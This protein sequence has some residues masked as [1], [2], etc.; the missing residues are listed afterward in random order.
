[1]PSEARP[2]ALLVGQSLE[3]WRDPLRAAVTA[4]DLDTVAAV[5]RR[6]LELG[7]HALDVNLG[8]SGDPAV[9]RAAL[10]AIRQAG[11]DV[12]LFLDT[13]DAR[14][15]TG[16]LGVV[17]GPVVTNAVPATD[18]DAPALLEAAAR[19]GAGVVLTPR[20][21][22]RADPAP[23][24]VLVR[25]LEDG[26]E[27]ARA[28]GVDGPLYLDCL[29]FPPAHDRPRALRSI[30]LLRFLTHR[31]SHETLTPGPSPQKLGRGERQ[32]NIPLVGVGNVGH[33]APERLRPALRRIYAALALGAGVG[34]LILPV[35][36]L[37]L[38][39]A[40]AVIEG[41]RSPSDASERW[42]AALASAVR[43]GARLPPPDDGVAGALREA[44]GLW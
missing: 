19:V 5:A 25:L 4:R 32:A 18:P 23:V 3:L 40:V 28:A 10:A 8:A 17:R 11:P 7:A 9:H 34:A 35:E 44:W 36:D 6:Q 24:E 30:A 41:R 42:L 15:L 26:V 27:Q 16:G 1:V 12:P 2:R 39:G 22:D 21:A 13:A 37:R 38:L 14:A 31:A 29:A 20:L 33:G 43:D